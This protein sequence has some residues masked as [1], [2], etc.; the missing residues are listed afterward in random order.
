[1]LSSYSLINRQKREKKLSSTLI[2]NEK[3]KIQI[4]YIPAKFFDK[5]LNNFINICS[6]YLINKNVDNETLHHSSA[7]RTWL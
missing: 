4:I 5:F 1:M 3:Y 6:T 7:K 2:T